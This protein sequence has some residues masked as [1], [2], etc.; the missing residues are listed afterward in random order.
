MRTKRMQML[1]FEIE[2]CRRN[3]DYLKERIETGREGEFYT[4]ELRSMEERLAMLEEAK[5]AWDYY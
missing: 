3:I 4:S 1:D 2:A 5:S